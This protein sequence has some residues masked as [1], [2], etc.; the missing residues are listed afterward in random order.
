MKQEVLETVIVP[1]PP[2]LFPIKREEKRNSTG[3]AK[4]RISPSLSN[5]S[6][7]PIP[8]YL[9]PSTG[10]CHDFCKYGRKHAF[11]IK[12][13]RPL[14]RRIYSTNEILGENHNEEKIP[15]IG[16]RRKR[17]IQKQKTEGPMN[18]MEKT[19]SSPQNSISSADELHRDL[20]SINEM[21]PLIIDKN[22]V[23]EELIISNQAEEFIE[24]PTIIELETPPDLASSN[25][26]GSGE[27]S[28]ASKAG[29]FPG[30]LLFMEDMMLETT[31]SASVQK[32]IVDTDEYGP[33]KQS[34]EE[35]KGPQSIT[36]KK[37]KSIKKGITSSK[38]KDAGS[39]QIKARTLNASDLRRGAARPKNDT[40]VKTKVTRQKETDESVKPNTIT[41]QKTTLRITSPRAPTSIKVNSSSS[42]VARILKP[43]TSSLPSKKSDKSTRA[44]TLRI[45]SP[46]PPTVIKQ[47]TPSSGVVRILKPKTSSPSK[48]SDIPVRATL[49]PRTPLIAKSVN[50]IS[51]I[52]ERRVLRSPRAS[53]SPKASFT[54]VPSIKLRSIAKNSRLASPKNIGK[55][56]KKE[57]ENNEKHQTRKLRS[58]SIASN[59][60]QK[61]KKDK[62][63]MLIKTGIHHRKT[64]PKLMQRNNVNAKM[65]EAPHKLSFRRGKVITPQAENTGP[66]WLRFRARVSNENQNGTV[67]Q[68]RSLRKRSGLG[69]VAEPNE[70]IAEA[71][72]VVL[73]HQEQQEKKDKQGLFNVVIE[74]TASKLVETRKSKV[75]ALVGAFETVIS[76]QEKKD[77]A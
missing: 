19:A 47:K 35:F 8:N 51:K 38:G 18:T 48:K 30:E 72:T 36:M 57:L 11:E 41:K 68:R 71:S 33:L 7:K 26:S 2:D 62:E 32:C 25:E 66:R 1:I 61:K 73:R 17:D 45:T 40:S 4:A 46:R 10:S 9:R 37:T 44:T 55:I 76:L 65:Q 56:G 63:G 13:R 59:S 23:T 54:S 58:S 31:P 5:S 12:E 16:N 77:Y 27:N 28:P 43:K 34:E 70:T 67:P 75:K 74:E 64:E 29:E 15:V 60:P 22:I 50:T 42:S 52:G 3:K 20:S 24:E 21:N 53:L 39:K 14:R 6:E 49:K 69:K